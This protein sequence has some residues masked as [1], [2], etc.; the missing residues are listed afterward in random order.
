MSKEHLEKRLKAIKAI[1]K[2]RELQQGL[3]RPII[4]TVFAGYRIP[5]FR[6]RM[7]TIREE[8]D[9]IVLNLITK[10]R[11]KDAVKANIQ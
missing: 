6:K 9:K 5:G 2:H 7:R 10:D 4:S 11:Y 1:Q 8:Q 3:G